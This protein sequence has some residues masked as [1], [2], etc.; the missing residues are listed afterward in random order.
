[1]ATSTAISDR[2]SF[3]RRSATYTASTFTAFEYGST[4]EYHG[5]YNTKSDE[6]SEVENKE[7]DDENNDTVSCLK[8]IAPWQ[9]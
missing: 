2:A 6:H 3:S 7:N 9:K 1:M 8:V 5:L 4:Y